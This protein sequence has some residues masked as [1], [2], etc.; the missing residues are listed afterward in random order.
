MLSNLK[1]P[2]EEIQLE[3]VSWNTE[4]R[5]ADS[6]SNFE[7]LKESTADIGIQLTYRFE[8]LH[9]RSIYADNGWKISLGRG[10]DI[11]DRIEGK[12][13]IADLDQTKRKCKACD[14]TYL[15]I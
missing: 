5:I 14:I 9:D 8:N 13:N 7:E 10:L 2:D 4:D 11:F 3:V 15:R 1:A 12:F 6:V